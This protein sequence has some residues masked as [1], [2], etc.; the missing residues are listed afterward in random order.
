MNPPKSTSAP[1]LEIGGL[2]PIPDAAIA[3]FLEGM[4]PS[5]SRSFP[6][7]LLAFPWLVSRGAWRQP[8]LSWRQC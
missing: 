7:G 5:I 1:A 2:T 6:L 8:C 4:Q 3:S